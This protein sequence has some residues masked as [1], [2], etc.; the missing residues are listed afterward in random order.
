[1]DDILALEGTVVTFWILAGMLPILC[2]F[3]ELVVP[4]TAIP[5]AALAT[6]LVALIGLALLPHPLPTLYQHNIDVGHRMNIFQIAVIATGLMLTGLIGGSRSAVAATLLSLSTVGGVLAVSAQNWLLL[7]V[8]LETVNIGLY[9][10]SGHWSTS[11]AADEALLKF[12]LMGTLFTAV[13]IAGIGLIVGGQG[14]LQMQPVLGA[15]ESVTIGM[16]LVLSTLLFKLGSFPFHIWTPDIYQGNPWPASATIASLPKVVA[17]S[18]LIHLV[19]LNQLTIIP[20]FYGLL[21]VL[22]LATLVVGALGAWQQ[23]Y[24]R[25]MLAYA[26]ISQVGFILLPLSIHRLGPAT[27]YLLTYALTSVAVFSAA[28]AVSGSHDP[29]RRDLMGALN[30]PA[31]WASLNLVIGLLGFAGFPLTIGMVGKLYTLEPLFQMHPLVGLIAVLTTA[32]SLFYYFRWIYPAFSSIDGHQVRPLD[33]GI[34]LT[35]QVLSAF[36]VILGLWAGP[37]N[38]IVRIMG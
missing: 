24:L 26:A 4:K 12:F 28:Q 8:G 6:G 5:R 10:L 33:P 2:L 32:L 1:M 14:T 16:T 3:L 25:R 29:S 18:I 36:V 22:A 21:M 7:F 30:S 9:G 23:N 17:G 20:R 19:T 27:V 35:T 15:N 31:K 13:E 38:W 11:H 34:I 37:F